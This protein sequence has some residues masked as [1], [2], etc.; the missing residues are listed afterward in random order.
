MPKPPLAFLKGFDLGVYFCF[1]EEMLWIFAGFKGGGFVKN[2]FP[3]PRKL[4]LHLCSNQ[5]DLSP[6]FP[7]FSSPSSILSVQF[8]ETSWPIL[9]PGSCRRPLARSWWSRSRHRLPFS[10]CFSSCSEEGPFCT[11]W[12]FPKLVQLLIA[13]LVSMVENPPQCSKLILTIFFIILHVRVP[14]EVC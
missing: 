13:I 6:L 2:P 12:F 5:P 8:W 11:F 3:S 9:F 14:H 4:P 10:G 7:S 1:A